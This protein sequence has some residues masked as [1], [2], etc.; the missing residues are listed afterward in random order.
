MDPIMITMIV[1]WLVVMAAA[2]LIEFLTYDLITS[3][4]ALGSVSGIILAACGVPWQWQFLTFL[5]VSLVCLVCFRRL[6]KRF[7]HVKT[8]PT[9][10]DANVGKR[11][12][13]T[14]DVVEGRTTIKLND[15]TW[16]AVCNEPLE[17]GTLVEVTE[18]QGNKFVVKQVT[19]SNPQQEAG[20]VNKKLTNKKGGKK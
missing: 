12:K 18:I 7:I 10:A 19:D 5:V 11:T 4:F 2:L 16:T 1:I 3:W 8:I 15:V 20:E 9:N 13:L 14:S 17:K 6:V